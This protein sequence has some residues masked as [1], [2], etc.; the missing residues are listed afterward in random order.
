M[1]QVYALKG[2]QSIYIGMTSDLKRRLEEHKKGQTYSTRRMGELTLIYV[3]S[4]VSKIDAVEQEKFYKTGYGREVLKE[5]LA[6]T[7]KRFQ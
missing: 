4:F 3:E 1:W 2:S 6:D 7:L 5:K